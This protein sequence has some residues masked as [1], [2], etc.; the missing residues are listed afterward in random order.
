MGKFEDQGFLVENFLRKQALSFIL[1]PTHP[2]IHPSPTYPSI[3]PPPP[4]HAP[5]YSPIHAIITHLLS[6]FFVPG[7]RPPSL[8]VNDQVSLHPQ[9]LSHENH[10]DLVT[11]TYVNISLIIELSLKNKHV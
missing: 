7:D 4:H 9:V 6:I 10:T 11:F 8:M 1:L 5:M 3:C 2:P